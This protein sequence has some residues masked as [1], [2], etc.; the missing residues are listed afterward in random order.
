MPQQ[1]NIYLDNNATTRVDERVLEAMLPYFT[2]LY[3]N[4]TSQ[5][6]AGLTV[7]EA[8]E[9]AAWQ[10]ADLINADAEE[11]IFT[12]GATEAIN[13][14]IKGLADQERKHI[15]T[16]ETEHK[17][18][19]ETCHFMESIGFNASYLPVERDGL[20]DLNLLN[21]T[22][23][24]KTLVFIGMFS[25]NETGVIQNVSKI[26]AILK[27]KNVLFLCDTTQA[28]GKISIDVKALGIDLLTMS[29]H[30]FYGPK[31][32]G[33][34]YL[35]AKAKIKL[36]PQITGGGH[37]KKLRSGTLNVPGIIGLGKAAEIAVNEL[38]NDKIRI[39]RLRNAL[40]KGL[41]QFK[42]SFVNG[43]IQNR[44][45]NTTNI[46]FP[47]VNSEQLIM[48]LGNISVS[49]GASCSAVTS[50]PSHVLKAMGL[51]DEEALS[52]IRFSL[53]RF[54]TEEEIDIAVERI[55]TSAEQL[56]LSLKR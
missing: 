37:Q 4:S 27:R 36:L 6:I 53:G 28:V 23:T 13:L 32:I 20:L 29:A 17:A 30:K 3:A 44:I 50:E 25:N 56:V 10:T 7:K 43:N 11:I 24:D 41:L 19:L 35:S 55:L 34:L 31:G 33:A 9:N 21:E 52:S 39:E 1:Q 15:V 26:S 51:S 2:D 40:E 12:S 47:G 14:A 16:L 8:I 49:N 5:H 54:T 22:V 46:C 48:A 42:G 18:V 45:Y 38:E